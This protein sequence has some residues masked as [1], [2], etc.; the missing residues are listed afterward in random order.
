MWGEEYGIPVFPV[1]VEPDPTHPGKM[2]KRPL[3]KGWQNGGAPT[4]PEVIE[5]LFNAHPNA[6]HVGLQ[7]GERSR[8]LAIDLDGEPGLEWWR[9]NSDLLPLTRTQRTRRPGGKHLL[10][11]IP[12]GCGL[13]NSASKFADGVDIRADGGFIV[14]WST[15]FPPEIEDITEAPAALIEFL[16][17]ATSRSAPPLAANRSRE[18]LAEG[19]GNAGLTR[20]AGKLRRSGLE[21]SEIDAALQ[22]FNHGRCVWPQLMPQPYIAPTWA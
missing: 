8:I 19:S 4:D 22:A 16:Q 14:D 9:N 17:H 10:Y 2:L 18:T 6:T 12:A 15:D 3:V 7:T 1:V 5:E 20:V 13:R 21:I 11:R